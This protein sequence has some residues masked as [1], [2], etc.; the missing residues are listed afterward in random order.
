MKTVLKRLAILPMALF[1]FALILALVIFNAVY[2]LILNNFKKKKRAFAE[3]N[4][5]Q[6]CFIFFTHVTWEHIW[7]RNQ[8]TVYRLSLKYPCIYF[9][10]MSIFDFFKHP[11]R[12]I[13]KR[14][15]FYNSNL[16]I[17]HP[18]TMVYENLFFFIN[19]LNDFVLSLSLKIRCRKAGFQNT[20]L[21]FYF[22]QLEKL[23]EKLENKL[24]V[25]DIQDEHSGFIWSRMDIGQREKELLKK[26]NL[27]FTGTL[28]LYRKKKAFV[29]HDNIFFFPCGVE[30]SFFAQARK[31]GLSL[32]EDVKNIPKPSIGYFG[33]IEERIDFELLEYIANQRP[34]LS[35]IMIGP[36]WRVKE[37]YLEIP[38]I[39]FLGRKEYKELPNYIQHFDICFMPFALN[40]LTMHINP[41]KLL[42]YFAAGKP[43]ISTAIP[44]VV[45]LYNDYLYIIR[46]K[47]ECV[48]YIDRILKGNYDFN[49]EEASEL[50]KN[51]SWEKMVEAMVGHINR[52]LKEKSS[53][54]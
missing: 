29:P 38:N 54:A 21:W 50:A 12:Y 36:Y 23:T 41:T 53:E 34:Q 9:E 1:S 3:Q 10:P 39:Y 11:I 48:K 33:S 43:V 18:V 24:I 31:G 14:I 2:L 40:E 47:E 6:L 44:D 5:E 16:M 8:H 4:K 37:K 46:S 19:R 45:E 42:E 51:N 20:I 17:Y 27:V 15:V 13:K 32:P 52:L 22:P 28:T 49:L 35:I 30:Y 26:A 7:Q 25:Y